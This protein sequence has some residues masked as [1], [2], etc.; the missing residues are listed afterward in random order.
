MNE[1]NPAYKLPAEWAAEEGIEIY[2]PDGWRCGHDQDEPKPFNIPVTK[3]E[4]CRR[5]VKS[6]VGP[7]RTQPPA[8]ALTPHEQ[9]VLQAIK[10]AVRTRKARDQAVSESTDQD[11][12]Q[13]LAMEYRRLAQA[14]FDALDKA[15]HN[16]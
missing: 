1:P 13:R 5:A 12:V 16:G 15:L 3:T 14:A 6:T 2:D 8:P 10:A 4:F 9:A 7:P 11:A